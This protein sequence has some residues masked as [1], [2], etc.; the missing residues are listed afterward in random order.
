MA[1]NTEKKVLIDVKILDN[2]ITSKK[3]ADAAK[4][5]L[6]D[7]L[8]SGEKNDKKQRELVKSLADTNNEYKEVKKQLES[9]AKAEQLFNEGTEKTIK[10]L[11]E[12]QRELS[13]LKNTPFDALDQKTADEIKM[14]MAGLMSDIAKYKTEIKGLI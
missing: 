12:M 8:E 7:F 9:S 6:D 1:E 13:A 11:G 14:R 10:T 4:K 5:A 3:N 2:F